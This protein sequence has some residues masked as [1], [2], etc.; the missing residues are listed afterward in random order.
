MVVLD[1]KELGHYLDSEASAEG[2]AFEPTGS[3]CVCEVCDLSNTHKILACSNEETGGF[4]LGGGHYLI[5]GNC[6]PL[7]GLYR[8]TDV[9]CGY[10]LSVCLLVL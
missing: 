9:D 1:S 2:K 4:W 8:N 10:N 6:C 3:R 5:D 7:A